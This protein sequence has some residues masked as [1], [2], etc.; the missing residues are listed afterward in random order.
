MDAH[1]WR[2]GIQLPTFG[3]GKRRSLTMMTRAI[4]TEARRTRETTMATMKAQRTLRRSSWAMVWEQRKI[5]HTGLGKK[6]E[7]KSILKEFDHRW[8]N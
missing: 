5:Q 3:P 4:C 8:N 7:Q 6:I 1:I 2:K